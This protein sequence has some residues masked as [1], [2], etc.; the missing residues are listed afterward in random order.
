MRAKSLRKLKIWR[1]IFWLDLRRPRECTAAPREPAC[2]A[3][4]RL[5]VSL[6]APLRRFSR[7]TAPPPAQSP[8]AGLCLRTTIK[9]VATTPYGRPAALRGAAWLEK[10]S[11]APR[12]PPL[13]A[14]RRL[15][16]SSSSSACAVRHCCLRPSLLPRPRVQ[17]LL[18]RSAPA[19]VAGRAHASS[20]PSSPLS[21]TT[22]CAW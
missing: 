5:S 19:A 20:A 2:A 22:T 1:E 3:G 15:A 14:L 7:A 4:V 11:C 21:M 13:A 8:L 6:A 16:A 9:E 12:Q 17:P 18:L 10:S